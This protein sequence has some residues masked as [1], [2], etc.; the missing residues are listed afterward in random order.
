LRFDVRI[1]DNKGR[2]DRPFPPGS[3]E[4]VA[5]RGSSSLPSALKVR[6]VAGAPPGARI[7]QGR[8]AQ[9]ARSKSSM[10]KEPDMASSDVYVGI[11][12][13]VLA[14]YAE[15]I[16]PE[17]RPLPDAQAQLLSALMARRSQLVGMIV[18]EKNRLQAASPAVRK[19][20]EEH[21]AWLEERLDTLEKELRKL[22]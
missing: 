8:T 15:A 3:L 13:A 9:G 1:S 10:G 6:T 22:V 17:P 12:A 21:L 11:D 7:L 2:G 18:A 4:T 19:G 20:I 5:E 14:R 16:Q